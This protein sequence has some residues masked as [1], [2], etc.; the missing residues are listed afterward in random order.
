MFFKTSRPDAVPFEGRITFTFRH[1]DR[2]IGCK[3]AILPMTKAPHV[4]A[5]S[6][7]HMEPGRPDTVL[8]Y[9]LFDDDGR[10]VTNHYHYYADQVR[11]Q[12]IHEYRIQKTA[13]ILAETMFDD[14]VIQE[15]GKMDDDDIEGIYL[16]WMKTHEGV[17]V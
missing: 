5:D 13:E 14:D 7:R 2:E 1:N 9:V 11:E 8:W 15:M 17:P 4:G 10:D 6:P 16:E 3:A 12:I